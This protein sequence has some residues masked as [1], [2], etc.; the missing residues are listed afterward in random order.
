MAKFSRNKLKYAVNESFFSRW[1]NQMAYVFGFTYADGNIYKTSLSWDVQKRDRNILKS[2]NKAMR[3]NYPIR[4]QRKCSYRLR[5]NN[6]KLIEQAIKKG[7]L[8]KKVCG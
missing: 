6:Q 1:T 4:L 3:S 7:L 8:P 5:I 2:I